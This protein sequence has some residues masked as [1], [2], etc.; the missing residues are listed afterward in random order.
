MRSRLASAAAGLLAL[1]SSSTGTASA[2]VDYVTSE[3]NSP[4]SISEFLMTVA[5]DT[6][7]LLLITAVGSVFTVGLVGYFWVSP[8]VKDVHVLRET[9]ASYK[10]LIPWMLRLSVGLPLIGAG[11]I[12][13]LFSPAVPAAPGIRPVLR[14][15]MV[16][17]GF[18]ILFGLAT[19]IVST[20]GLCLYLAVLVAEPQVVL[21]IEYLPGFVALMIVG[22][23]RPSADHMLQQ[24]AS[25]GGT[26]Y[27]RV[28]PVHYLKRYLDDVTEPYLPLVPTIIRVG[29]GVSFVYLGLVQKLG[30][31][32][33]SLAVVEKYSLTSVVP[34]AP[35]LWVFGAAVSEI[36]VGLALICGFATR[37]AAALAFGL[38]TLTLFGLP[39]DPVLAH[40]PLFG[41]T[42][43]LFITGAGRYALDNSEW[44]PSVYE[45]ISVIP[46]S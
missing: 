38:F 19:R 44:T 15:V 12:G 17:L 7:S 10:D 29:L 27:G 16:G 9:L 36:L 6:G 28:D 3:E 14:L 18:L 20:V 2:H 22:G 13:Y 45:S 31:P 43:A 24:V 21:A 8:Q 35:E 26:L 41:F 33:Q 11:F 1:V 40:V 4:V 39:D 46:E 32:G 37:G 30:A 42:S 25:T 5:S 23:G 34:V